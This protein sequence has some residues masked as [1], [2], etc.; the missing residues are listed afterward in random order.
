MCHFRMLSDGC[1]DQQETWRRDFCKMWAIPAISS[2]LKDAV[3]HKNAPT[4]EGT[5]CLNQAQVRQLGMRNERQGGAR[6]DE[7]IIS[8]FTWSCMQR[9]HMV[10]VS[11]TPHGPPEVMPSLV[12]YLDRE[13]QQR[14]GGC[15]YFSSYTIPA[16]SDM[17]VKPVESKGRKGGL[18]TLTAQWSNMQQDHKYQSLNHQYHSVSCSIPHIP[19]VYFCSPL[20]MFVLTFSGPLQSPRSCIVHPREQQFPSSSSVLPGSQISL[21]YLSPSLPH[22]LS[23]SLSAF[24]LMWGWG[25]NVSTLSL[26]HVVGI[27]LFFLPSSATSKSIT[28]L[29]VL[30]LRGVSSHR[31]SCWE[32]VNS[33][34]GVSVQQGSGWLTRLFGLLLFTAGCRLW[35]RAADWTRL[36]PLCHMRLLN[37]FFFQLNF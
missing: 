28:D 29:D 12:N 37:V 7:V 2:W 16:M 24:T 13:E 6:E 10:S 9:K 27:F 18:K 21:S 34:C 14:E 17:I 11:T 8:H 22:C 32:K 31:L 1:T 3:S 5:E 33:H 26:K 23:H 4:Y 25:R 30:L 35:V 36:Y 19:L 15:C 20:F